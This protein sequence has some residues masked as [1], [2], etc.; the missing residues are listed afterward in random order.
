M[1]EHIYQTLCGNDLEEDTVP[2]TFH[3]NIIQLCFTLVAPFPWGGDKFTF[4]EKFRVRKKAL[5]VRV[6]RPYK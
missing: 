2:A 1:G 4:V 6:N 5:P 3:N